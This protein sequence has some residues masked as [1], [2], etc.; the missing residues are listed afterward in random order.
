MVHREYCIGMVKVFGLEKGVSWQRTAEVHP[1]RA[2][3][4]QH[5]NDGVYL[6]RSHMTAFASMRVKPANQ[7]VRLGNTK[8]RAQVVIEN[9]DDL[10]QQVGR[11]RLADGFQRQMGRH[12]RHPQLL[13]RQHHHH[14]AGLR[15]LFE[16][17]GMTGEGDA[18]VVDVAFVH[19]AGH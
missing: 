16:E 14:F 2:H 6:F 18:G 11:Y 13:G 7:H 19:R 8:F 5:R 10:A 17:L 9:R 4:F 3:L 12:Q 1:L 15:A